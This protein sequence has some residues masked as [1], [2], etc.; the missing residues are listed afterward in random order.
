MKLSFLDPLYAAPDPVASVYLDTSRDIGDPDKAVEL[1]WRHLRDD[2]TAQGAD[3]ATVAAL[4]EMVRTDQEVPGRHGKALFAAHGRLLLAEEL[5]EPPVRDSARLGEIPDALP[6]A[7]Q[8]APD[9]PYVAVAVRRE[10]RPEPGGKA[11]GQGDV[12]DVV[13]TFQAGRW[14][15]SRVAPRPLVDREWRA[16]DGERGAAAV[17]AKLE[18]MVHRSGAEVIVLHVEEN[19][20]W[21]RGVLLNR[22]SGTLRERT[23]TVEAGEGR[24]VA[25]PRRALLEDEVGKV[26]GGRL[27]ARDRT[28]TDTYRAQRARYP[29]ASEGLAATVAAL[30]RGQAQALLVNRP[31][32]LTDPLWVGPGNTQISLSAEELRLFGGT[33][34]RQERAGAALLRAAAGTGAELTV[35]PRDD[36]PMDDGVGVLLRYAPGSPA[37]GQ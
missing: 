36:M 6:L 34:V 2:L 30:R 18:D 5:P 15:M 17:A 20:P 31:A 28:H 26:L 9:I 3:R 8:H 35:V 29:D 13:A 23:V 12:L 27:S 25:D 7:V 21:A 14:P 37:P 4:S 11:G 32:H 24:V 1:R 10:R 19:D 33:S 16:E 22:L